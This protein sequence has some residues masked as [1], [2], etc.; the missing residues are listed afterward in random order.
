LSDSLHRCDTPSHGYT[1][2][3]A[4]YPEWPRFLSHSKDILEYLNHVVETLE[5]GKYINVNCQVAEARWDED[6]GKWRLK[7]QRVEP[8][9]DWTS[10]EPLKVLSEFWDEADLLL[11]ATGILNR[12]D[13]PKIPGLDK[14]KGRVIHTAGWPDNFAE[15]QWKGLNVAVIGSGASSVQTVPTM[16]VSCS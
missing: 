12:W 14:F 2:P 13:Y 11:H 10:T 3:W 4:P 1:Y 15:D 16:Q 7:I 6:R 9:R 8:K 5:L